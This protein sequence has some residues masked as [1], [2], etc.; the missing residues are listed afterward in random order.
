M[1]GTIRA[2]ELSA[3]K[4]GNGLK[5]MA[6]SFLPPPGGPFEYAVT[7]AVAATFTFFGTNRTARHI[8]LVMVANWIATRSTTYAFDQWEAVA[9]FFVDVASIGF[10]VIFG[11]NRAKGAVAS[12]F[13]LMLACYMLHDIGVLNRDTM[14]AWVDLFAYLQIVI[15]AGIASGGHPV[16]NSFA[17]RAHRGGGDPHRLEESAQK[18]R[19]ASRC[20]DRDLCSNQAVFKEAQ[21]TRLDWDHY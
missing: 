5:D 21:A 4:C 13:S 1:L 8:A 11:I 17:I 6:D 12:L 19:S 20:S 3:Q 9:T 10:L 14:W 15:M 7:L 2:L 18:R 16:F